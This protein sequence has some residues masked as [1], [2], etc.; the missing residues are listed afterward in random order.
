MPLDKLT[1]PIQPRPLSG[2][3][4]RPL[5]QTTAP[6]PAPS[7]IA[8]DDDDSLGGALLGGAALAGSALL[9]KKFGVR[10]LA[11]KANALRQQ[12]MLSGFAL[13]KSLLGNTGA[14]IERSVDTKSL[15]PVKEMFSKQTF[16]DARQAYRANTGAVGAGANAPRGATLPGPMPGRLM[17]AFDEAS[18]KALGRSGASAKEAENAVLQSPL[19]QGLAEALDNPSMRYVHPF[20]RTPFNQFIEGGKRMPGGS[21]GTTHGKIAY[22]ATGAVHGA[23]TADDNT[24]VSIPLATALAS[25]YGMTYAAAALIARHMAGGGGAAGIAS[26]MLPVSEYGIDQSLTD[27]LRPFTKPAAFTALEKLTR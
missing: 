13:P 26:S 4:L 11:D 17:G 8:D 9:A 18:Q 3:T 6:T 14:A 2:S 27:P 15:R 25:R 12:L 10:N 22:G 21:A 24:P 19:P 20:R 16:D 5:G 7:T 23:A 1:P